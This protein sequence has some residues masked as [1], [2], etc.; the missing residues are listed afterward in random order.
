MSTL[1]TTCTDP[2]SPAASE[3]PLAAAAGPAT[4]PPSSS[5]S[6]SSSSHSFPFSILSWNILAD[7]YTRL[8]QFPYTPPQALTWAYRLP[9]VLSLLSRSPLPSILCLQEVDHYPDLHTHLSSLGYATIYT[10]RTWP[11]PFHP[12]SI[13]LSSSPPKADGLLLA[14]LPSLFLPPPPPSI[15]H[16]NDLSFTCPPSDATRFWRQN[17]AVAI[18]LTP[19]MAGGGG[20][21]VWV[22]GTHLF[23][24]PVYEDVKVRQMQLILRWVEELRRERDGE[25]IVAGDFNSTPQ[26]K[27]YRYVTRGGLSGGGKEGGGGGEREGKEG[28]EEEEEKGPPRLLVEKGLF[29]LAKWLRSIGLDTAYHQ[30]DMGTR[31]QIQRFFDQAVKE[32]RIIV[33]KSKTL[34]QRR[35]C[36]ESFLLPSTASWESMLAALVGH[37]GLELIPSQFYTRCTLCNGTFERVTVAELGWTAPKDAPR[38]IVE[39]GKDELGQPLTFFRCVDCS[40]VYWWGSKSHGSA[41][42]FK[43]APL[44]ST[45][46]HRPSSALIGTC[47]PLPPPP[48]LP[49]PPPLSLLMSA[50]GRCSIGLRGA[51]KPCRHSRCSRRRGSKRRETGRR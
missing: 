42:K 45:G 21:G 32:Q 26:S 25:V 7:C 51:T 10:P 18:H 35:H 50:L 13:P 30:D 12:P 38:R 3:A 24:S 36:P 4:S 37:F 11:H 1:A 15:L 31:E 2:P 8:G 33:T 19:R 46:L 22:V 20:Q 47:L 14:Y 34:C 43:S 5:S 29:R 48:P 49:H 27:V 44:H 39:E 9:R 6:C 23:W 16:L 17:I 28:V 40:Q 41:R